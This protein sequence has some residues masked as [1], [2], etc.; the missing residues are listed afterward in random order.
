MFKGV[1]AFAIFSAVLCAQSDT[2][3]L[4]GTVTDPSGLG[5]VGAEVTLR[6]TATFGRRVTVTDIQGL[7]HFSLLVP[8]QYDLTVM[9]KGFVEH[10]DTQFSLQV[11]QAGRLNVEL[12]VGATVETIQVAMGVSILNTDTAAQGTVIGHEKIASLPLNGRQFLQLALLVPGANP[13]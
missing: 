11:A 1:L 6:N 8:G 5:V 3:S 9:A 7:Y 4:S 13:G 12:V 2:A 10:H